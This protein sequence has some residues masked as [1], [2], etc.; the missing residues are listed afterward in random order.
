MTITE[1]LAEIKLIAKKVASKQTFVL[2]HLV[3]ED[4]VEDPL[5][6]GPATI[7]KELQ[8]IGDLYRRIMD[9]RAAIAKAN[10][11][12]EIEIDGNKRSIYD[13]LTWK[14]EI[15]VSEI[16]FVSNVHTRTKQLL[17]KAAR[18]PTAYKDANGDP[19]FVKVTPNVDYPAFAKKAQEMQETL[20]KLD[21]QLSLKNATIVIEV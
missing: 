16:G 10:I 12:N 15:A 1:G 17:D 13:W 6:D 19:K 7:A 14:R 5:K 2:E 8:S 11:Q 9:I 18:Q 3:R 4:H 21:G 20:D